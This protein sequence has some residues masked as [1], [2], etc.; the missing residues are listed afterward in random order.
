[1]FWRLFLTFVSL[2]A[3][4]VVLVGAVVW[5]RAGD[6]FWA[7]ATDVALAVAIIVAVSVPVA[8]LLAVRF[9]RPILELTLG[10]RRLA[11]GD[12]GHAIHVGGSREATALAQTFNAMSARLAAS[13]AQ[14]EQDRQQLRTILSGMV[15]GVVAFDNALRVLFANDRAAELLEVP[16]DQIVGRK[17]W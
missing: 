16:A 10:A 17:L 2:V 5:Y 4:A 3:L 1:M 14:V 11:E 9:T 6:L 13:F 8:Y 12:F 7:L 15:E